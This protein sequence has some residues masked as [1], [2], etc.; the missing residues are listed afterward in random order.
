[1]VLFIGDTINSPIPAFFSQFG[2]RHRPVHGRAGRGARGA[3][4]GADAQLPHRRP[5]PAAQGRR[6]LLV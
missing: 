3:A 6:P 2:G 5:V 4:A 1:M